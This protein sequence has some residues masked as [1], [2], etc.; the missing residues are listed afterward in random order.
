MRFLQ[1]LVLLCSAVLLALVNLLPNANYKGARHPIGP[2][3]VQ[4]YAANPKLIDD[5]QV[6]VRRFDDVILPEDTGER[7]VVYLNTDYQGRELWNKPRSTLGI[8]G[9]TALLYCLAGF[10]ARRTT[11]IAFESALI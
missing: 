5:P 2:E 9:V 7:V 3:V 1:P 11:I 10:V 4:V 8:V 6:S